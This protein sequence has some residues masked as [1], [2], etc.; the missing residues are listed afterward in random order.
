MIGGG[1]HSIS[2]RFVPEWLKIKSLKMLDSETLHRY[3]LQVDDFIGMFEEESRAGKSVRVLFDDV[4]KPVKIMMNLG[5]FIRAR[6]VMKQLL[7]RSSLM[8]DSYVR[9]RSSFILGFIQF[10]VGDFADA[11]K[12]YITGMSLL[13]DSP[14]HLLQKV[15]QFSNL[16]MVTG[17]SKGLDRAASYTLEAIR[18]LN[19]LQKTLGIREF[20]RIAQEC[21]APDF[22]SQQSAI[23]SNLGA[24]YQ[25]MALEIPSGANREH[26]LTMAIRHHIRSIQKAR[27]TEDRLRSMANFA[28][29]LIH[30]NEFSRADRILGNIALRCQES[31][32]DRLLS[33][34]TGFRAE[35][36]L[37]HENHEE[38]LKLCHQSLK[39]A[40]QAADPV[41]EGQSIVIAMEPLKLISSK[42]FSGDIAAPAFRE[43][44]FPIIRQILD[45]LEDKDWYTGRDHSIGVGKIATSM[46]DTMCRQHIDSEPDYDRASLEMAA[47]LHDVGKLWIP[48]TI[49]NRTTPLWPEEFEIIR[50]HPKRG[51]DFLVELGFPLIGEILGRHHER[52]D[53]RGYPRGGDIGG[54]AERILAVADCYE[55]MTTSNRLYRDPLSKDAAIRRIV[56]LGGHQFDAA[57]ADLL[58]DSL[59]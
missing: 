31:G 55:A 51:Q 18:L 50:S 1:M 3:W 45:F 26:Y 54:T 43:S 21:C 35:A 47:L 44:G 2:E 25:A 38:A 36:A 59:A 4:L 22:F 6:H 24:I 15:V 57:V 52:P 9:M 13:D 11:E 37:K 40:I 8:N 48:W 10:S 5:D 30:R 34:I 20:D 33:W 28:L 56:N 42:A 58:P 29:A 27:S 46:F 16:G 23:H 17:Y 41:S 39:Y 14:A 49:L 32:S 53:G 12:C 19:Q 7:E